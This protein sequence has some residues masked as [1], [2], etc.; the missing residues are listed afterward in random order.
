MKDHLCIF[1][2]PNISL[3]L[4]LM[5]AVYMCIENECEMSLEATQCVASK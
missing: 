3:H 1:F 2:A 5:F 4:E